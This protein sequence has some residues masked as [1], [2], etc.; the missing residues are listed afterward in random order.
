MCLNT[1]LGLWFTVYF[2]HQRGNENNDISICMYTAVGESCFWFCCLFILIFICL[3][4]RMITRAHT[5]HLLFW[6][7]AFPDKDE[8]CLKLICPG[9]DVLHNKLWTCD[10]SNQC[11]CAA[12]AQS[13]NGTH[14]QRTGCHADGFASLQH[15]I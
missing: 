14:F 15:L 5:V 13:T 3:Y 1:I 6:A 8:L 11:R 12:L 4:W 7:I 9:Q 2:L 10:D